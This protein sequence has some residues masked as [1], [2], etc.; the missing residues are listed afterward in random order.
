MQGKRPHK[1]KPRP[2]WE[3]WRSEELSQRGQEEKAVVFKQTVHDFR[4]GLDAVVALQLAD[5]ALGAVGQHTMPT[6]ML[7]RVRISRVGV[8]TKAVATKKAA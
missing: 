3:R 6:T 8:L 1:A 7:V 2:E 5:T 4:H